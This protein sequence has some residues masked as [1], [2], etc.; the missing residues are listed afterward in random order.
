[1]TACC[2]NNR[3]VLIHQSCGAQKAVQWMMK[4]DWAKTDVAGYWGKSTNSQ[5]MWSH[6]YLLEPVMRGQSTEHQDCTA[7]R[8]SLHRNLLNIV[9]NISLG[10]TILLF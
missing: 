4:L 6:P 10:G 8:V 9:F 1:M 7:F 3:M 5:A 2:N